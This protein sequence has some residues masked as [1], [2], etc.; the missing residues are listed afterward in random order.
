MSKK[1][2]SR[3][4]AIDILT[5]CRFVREAIDVLEKQAYDALIDELGS[6]IDAETLQN[7]QVE[8]AK[9]ATP[10]KISVLPV[11]TPPRAKNK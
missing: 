2:W 6:Y 5:E 1:S 8:R 7:E 4:E 3:D 11:P 10:G 9:K